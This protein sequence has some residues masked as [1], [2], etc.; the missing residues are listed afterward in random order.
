VD[1]IAHECF[2]ASWEEM[3]FLKD[4][5]AERSG[6]EK[7]HAAIVSDLTR[8]LGCP[9]SACFGSAKPLRLFYGRLDEF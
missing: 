4:A 1:E 8:N 7:W 6:M 2:A 3:N 5:P 9:D